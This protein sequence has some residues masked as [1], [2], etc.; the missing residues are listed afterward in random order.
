[1][2]KQVISW[3]VL[4][5][6][7]LLLSA[8]GGDSDTGPEEVRWDREICARCAMAVS[9]HRFAAEVRGG[10]ADSKS[11]V[12]KFDDLGCAVVWLD[13]QPWKDNPATEIWIKDHQT[14]QWLD[15]RKAWYV[16]AKNTPMDYGLA[17]QQQKTPDALTFA[18]AKQQIF[19]KEQH[20]GSHHHAAEPIHSAEPEEK[21]QQG[22]NNE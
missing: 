7:V 16:K 5:A 6:F 21:T 10:P 2:K 4:T 13:K 9:D 11:K 15:A 20:A 3:L 17:A 1:M 22:S 12:Y 8:C 19:A 14:E 18:Q